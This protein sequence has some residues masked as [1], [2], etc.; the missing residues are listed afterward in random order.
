MAAVRIVNVAPGVLEAAMAP[1]D[2]RADALAAGLAPVSDI[3]RDLFGISDVRQPSLAYAASLDVQRAGLSRLADTRAVDSELTSSIE[4]FLKRFPQFDASNLTIYVL[5]SFGRFQAQSRLLNGKPVLLIDTGF[6]AT[7]AAGV[8]Y[9]PFVHHELV[10]LYHYQLRPD[11]GEAAEAFFHGGPPPSLA[12]AL[13]LEGLA[14]HTARELNPAAPDSQLFPSADIVSATRAQSP[15]LLQLVEARAGDARI[16]AICGFFYFPC[17]EQSDAIPLNSG[18]VLGERLVDRMLKARS[19]EQ[20]MLLRDS[21]VTAAIRQ[22]AQE[23]R[24][25][26]GGRG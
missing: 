23:I 5:P 15:R 7:L 19:L 12:T 2:R 10:H 17:A 25:A 1:A 11:L 9:R 3:Y 22:A 18:Y 24:L 26:S 14:V 8:I 20:V 6:F 13:W 21:D 16:G 4:V